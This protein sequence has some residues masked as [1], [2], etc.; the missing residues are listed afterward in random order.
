MFLGQECFIVADS[1][2]DY[3]CMLDVLVVKKVKCV[4]GLLSSLLL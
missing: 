4:V 3:N 2:L 1:T